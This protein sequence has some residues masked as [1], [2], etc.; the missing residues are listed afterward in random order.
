MTIRTMSI[1]DS[2]ILDAL[3]DFGASMFFVFSLLSLSRF[4]FS[5][6]PYINKYLDDKTNN[7]NII[8]SYIA[9]Y[10]NQ[11][12]IVLCIVLTLLILFKFKIHKPKFSFRKMIIIFIYIY[13]LLRLC[14][15]LFFSV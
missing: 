1:G 8:L 3:S 6:V 14:I 7:I 4:I 2:T 11:I 5:K 10:K 15:Q 12:I 13:G 9:T